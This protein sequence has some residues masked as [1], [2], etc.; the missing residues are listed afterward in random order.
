MIKVHCTNLNGC[1]QSSDSASNRPSK[2]LSAICR[3]WPSLILNCAHL[4]S[5]QS[6]WLISPTWQSSALITTALGSVR[7]PMFQHLTG[8]NLIFPLR[9]HDGSKPVQV[10]L[11]FDPA[12]GLLPGFTTMEEKSKNLNSS[13]H[14]ILWNSHDGWD[15]NTVSHSSSIDWWNFILPPSVH[16]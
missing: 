4:G 6:L 10:K 7:F 3:D 15:A 5:R 11:V 1:Q 9:M 16:A 13:Y 8:C 2:Y 12:A 14:S